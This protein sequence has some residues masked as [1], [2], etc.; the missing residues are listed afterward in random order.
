MSNINVRDYGDEAPGS[1]P[2]GTTSGFLDGVTADIQV[3]AILDPTDFSKLVKV[4]LNSLRVSETSPGTP[5][6]KA[7]SC[8]NGI[9]TLLADCSTAKSKVIV[10]NFTTAA[11]NDICYFGGTTVSASTGYALLDGD[12]YILDNFKGKL[13][14]YIATTTSSIRVTISA[15]I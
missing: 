10:Q 7:I 11:T 13:Y 3:I 14:A 1:T 2:V 9:T 8:T 12:S 6:S 15:Y 5:I 4:D